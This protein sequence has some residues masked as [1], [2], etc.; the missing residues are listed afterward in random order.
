MSAYITTSAGKQI[1]VDSDDLPFLSQ[2]TWCISGKYAA[3]RIKGKLIYLH[4]LLMN[5]PLHLRVDHINGNPFDNRRSNLRLCTQKENSRNQHR[6]KKSFSGYK[7]VSFRQDTQR[8]QA[9][10]TVNGKKISLGCFDQAHTAARVYN[11]AAH[12][13]FGVFAC[14]N[15]IEGY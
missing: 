7:G 15:V 12:R 3:S 11:E 14:M 6:K 13:Y 9:Y 10:I 1:L 4:R 8:W 2:Y 5:P